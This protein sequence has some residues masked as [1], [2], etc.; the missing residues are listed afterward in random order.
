MFDFDFLPIFLRFSSLSP[1]RSA[2][3]YLPDETNFGATPTDAD[4]RDAD[5]GDAA[6]DGAASHTFIWWPDSAKRRAS[7]YCFTIR[8]A[9]FEIFIFI[10]SK[11]RSKKE[12]ILT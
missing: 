1:F 4:K 11:Y 12:K 5:R 6:C 2:D 10:V 3:D 7:T 9:K 8:M